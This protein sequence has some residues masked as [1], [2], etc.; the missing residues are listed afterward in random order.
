MCTT[1]PTGEPIPMANSARFEED[2]MRHFD[3]AY[4]L[5][6]WLCGNEAE[7]QDLVQEA[8]L[9]A[10]RYFDGFRGEHARA[11][12]LSIVRHTFYTQRAAAAGRA[13][14]DEFDETHHAVEAVASPEVLVLRLA[15]TQRLQAALASL[16]PEF[17]EVL[18]LRE[19]EDCSYKEIAAITKLK[20]G[21]VMSRLA[22]AR[23]R[24]AQRLGDA[25]QEG[26]H[27]AV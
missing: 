12:L 4:N 22:R 6:R 20:I 8:L 3:A 21:T 13:W 11:W 1:G 23:E 15:D 26:R 14:S 24:L 5:A 9:R 2:V 27:H 16:A 25:A 19:L 17:R 18:V 7:A 10:F